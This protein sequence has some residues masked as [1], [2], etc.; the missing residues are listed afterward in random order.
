MYDKMG[1][2]LMWLLRILFHVLSFIAGN[3]DK[4]VSEEE[5]SSPTGYCPEADHFADTQ[6][7]GLPV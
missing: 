3:Q 6:A 5:V 2:Q 1:Q 7:L 4:H